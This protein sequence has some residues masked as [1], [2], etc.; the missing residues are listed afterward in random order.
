MID[1]GYTAK[2]SQRNVDLF[3]SLSEELK[4]SNDF[5][6]TDY[7]GLNMTQT[8]QLRALLMKEGAVIQVVKNRIA[9]RALENIGVAGGEEYRSLLSG[10][11]ALVHGSGDSFAAL[12]VLVDFK[13]E[14]NLPIMKGAIIDNTFYNA[15]QVA[16]VAA[17]PSRQ[18]LLTQLVCTMQAP[19]QQLASLLH[20]LVSRP[21]IVLN[22]IAKK[23][24]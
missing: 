24:K 12:R 7:R 14:H 4:R 19:V 9:L 20:T 18:Q 21:I 6:F 10:P 8:I 23:K 17:L 11:T 3:N 13:K 1:N 2:V 22:E 5:L 15:E 16:T